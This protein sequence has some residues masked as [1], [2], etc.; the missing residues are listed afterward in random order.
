[1]PLFM[2]RLPAL[3]A[4]VA[5]LLALSPSP[6][7]AARWDPRLRWHTLF[8]EHFAIHF[9]QG[10]N[11]LAI[12]MA[13][14][15]EEIHQLLVPYMGWEPK[16]RTQVVIVDPT[17]SANGYA[18]TIPHN[19][20]VIYAVQPSP[21]TSLDNYEHWLWSIFVHEYAH[22]LQI[23][24]VG[25]IPHVLR[26]IVGRMIVPGAV[27]P[28]WM[29]E[30]FA[31]Y[32]ETRFT[33]GGRGRST[34]TD[35]LLRTA[36]LERK[37]PTIDTA[38]GYG[39]KWPRGQL[40]YL[41]GARFHFK[42]E[43]VSELGDRAWVDF[44]QR[45]GRGII[46]F[47]LPAKAS[48][49]QT[50]SRIWK[51]W[52]RELAGSYLDQAT[53][54]ASQGRGLTPTRVIATREGIA[55]SPRYTPDGESIT[56]SHSSPHERSSLR[57]VRRDGA[58]EKRLWRG[59]ASR[60]V[61]APGG[62]RLYFT[63]ISSTNRYERYSDLFRF[64]LEKKKRK[65]LSRGARLSNPAIHPSGEWLVAVQTW[66]GQTQL[67]RVDLPEKQSEAASGGAAG[68]GQAGEEG[69]GITDTG[70]DGEVQ[71]GK[72][73]ALLVT[74]ITDAADG[75]QYAHPTWDRAGER[76]AVSVWKPGG[77]R[78]IHVFNSSG[79]H[80]RAL[81]WDRAGDTD[82]VFSPD[83]EWIVFASDRDDIWNLYA[84]RW[85]DGSF[86]RVT[87]LLGGAKK[88][89]FSP[90]GGH[91]VF[92]GYAAEG[93]RIE[94]VPF[95]PE[96]LESYRVPARA[97]P[98][99]NQG[100]SA[101]ALAPLHP[102]EGVP[103]PDMPHGTAPAKAVARARTQADFATL[104]EAPEP[105][106]A[107]A[108]SPGPREDVSSIPEELG[109]VKRYNPLRTL[110]PPRYIS[111]FG[112]LT[113]TGALGG[114]STG[115]QD[116]LSQH[117][118]SASVHYRT[119]SR[120]FG[121]SGGYTLNAF[122]PRLSIVFSSIALDYGRILLR[123]DAPPPPG[124]TTFGGVFQGQER[125]FE[126]RDRLSAGVSIPIKLHHALSARYKLEFRRP[127]NK[128]PEDADPEFLPARGSFSGLVL[129][130]GWGNFQ[131]RP[132][133]IS[134]EGSW[135]VSVSV[136]IE[137]SYLGAYRLQADG[138]KLDLHRAIFSAEGRRYIGLP[139]GKGHV[140]ALRAM[141]GGTVGT[142][143]PQR[144]FRMG[145]AYGDNSY[146]SL[147][148]RY[149]GL[150]GYRTSG[151]RG[152]HIWLASAEYRLPLAHI[153]RGLWTAPIWLRSI[154]LTVFA[155]AGQTFDTEDYAEFGGNEEGF[156]TF[157]ENTRPSVGVELVGDVIIGW[158]AYF[159]GRVGYAVGFGS[160]AL[161][162]GAF[163]AQLGS[164]F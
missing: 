106:P 146:V 73:D 99:P 140:L 32:I 64:D 67:V 71:L 22:I 55:S 16:F 77:F 74:P 20:I 46:P 40:R 101:M 63:S 10:E 105:A 162:G 134:P 148:D 70:G 108:R 76:F 28:G 93:W 83:G 98:G 31:T 121:G 120:Y 136:D 66:R 43:Q 113:D 4:L 102:L 26:Q 62:E 144:T 27:L 35:M 9:H 111:L 23:D 45:H 13:Q 57:Q 8:T 51:D 116:A 127:L 97:L 154:A 41:Y 78:D 91:L 17:D 48:F 53:R 153:E 92:M 110:F 128:L 3:L 79:E 163:Y 164:S 156:R 141:A 112:S 133:G 155:E 88:P 72:G 129:G 82:P 15:A 124:G 125:Y 19:A 118:W 130:W 68:T 96:Q 81:T 37:L 50:F 29:T 36:A 89:D 114:I 143:I 75:T 157:W 95:L 158:G 138:S 122:H 1:M 47:Y 152:N 159:Q 21:E 161:P 44:H 131:R 38:E 5:T 80:L 65:R 115:G 151:M 6:T 52:K 34:Y 149:Y 30:G 137:S 86:F 54:I 14:S 59:G 145:G 49:G 56:Y 142:D 90:D 104:A 94:E 109:K 87:R 25:G 132:A 85:A 69:P 58:E 39:H 126:R 103:G 33:A 24:M 12:E 119:D 139:W 60:P 61:W 11:D 150:R 123:N 18:T 84:Y 147:P 7:E 100:P 117:A 2:S 160:G 42:A 107:K 135:L